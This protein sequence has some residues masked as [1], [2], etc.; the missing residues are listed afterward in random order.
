LGVKQPGRKADHFPPPSTEVKNA[1]IYT[2]PSPICHH[3]MV[4]ILKSDRDNF[5]FTFNLHC[6]HNLYS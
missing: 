5:T 3:G 1:W 4:L 2:S 6:F